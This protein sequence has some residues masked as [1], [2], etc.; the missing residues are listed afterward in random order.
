[1]AATYAQYASWHPAMQARYRRRYGSAPHAPVASTNPPGDPTVKPWSPWS[2][3]PP[4]G[5]YDPALD[6][7]VG[8]AGRGLGD[9]QSD[10]EKQNQR[11]TVDYGLQREDIT[12]SRDQQLSDLNLGLTRGGEDYG[13]N[14]ALLDR[15]YR[16]TANRQQQ[17]MNAYGVLSGGAALQAAQK[18]AANEAIDRQPLDTGFSRLQA[19]TATGVKR[20]T[21]NADLALGKLALMMA[22]PDAQNPMGGRSFQDRTTHLTRAE[23]ENSQFGIDT[24]AQK[25]FQAA[26]T[27]WDPGTRPRGEFVGPN[28][29]YRVLVRGNYKYRY[30]PAGHVFAKVLRSRVRRRG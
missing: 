4:T 8:A 11:D 17:Q 1:M 18:R 26:G 30:D 28:G 6:A 15:A 5:T 25:A 20:T 27:G 7:A 12:R 10:V 16:S 21:D 13:R 2:S 3:S 9:L 22:P 29:P 14:V 19:D 23:R 24:E